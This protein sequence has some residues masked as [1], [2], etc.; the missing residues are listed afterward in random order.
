MSG[1]QRAKGGEDGEGSLGPSPPAL[2]VLTAALCAMLPALAWGLVACNRLH[3]QTA[4]GLP[5]VEVVDI[6][7]S[8]TTGLA[9]AIT[10]THIQLIQENGNDLSIPRENVIEL[11]RTRPLPATG[12]PQHTLLLSNGDRLQGTI[13]G[14]TEES[15]QLQWPG[16]ATATPLDVP[17]ELIRAIVFAE[18]SRTEERDRLTRMWGL[19]AAPVDRL[20][21]RTGAVIDGEL[22]ELDLGTF[23]MQT[24][25]GPVETPQAEV[26]AFAGNPELL[27]LPTPPEEY[28]IA[29][30]A[31][32]DWISLQELAFVDQRQVTGQT[33][34]G[35]NMAIP[36]DQIVR[37]RLFG[38]RVTSL[39]ALQP[40][41]FTFR[42]WL[43]ESHSLVANRNVHGGWLRLQ[44]DTYPRGMGLHSHSEVTY[45]L[46]GKY[47]RFQALVGIDDM[48]GPQGSVTFTVE[49]DGQVAFKSDRITG[50]QPPV[51]VGPLPV[52][53]AKQLRLTVD[54][55]DFGNIRDIADVVKPL[56][57]K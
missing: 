9:S 31:G 7:G 48:A 20:I 5:S 8:V 56:L 11:R 40:S 45:D 47:E 13:T 57:T 37:L 50:D 46:G 23:R 25:L 33:L 24:S 32:G 55:A 52:S 26:A 2:R 3:A 16:G 41:D 34:W 10:P 36:L 30:C 49:V 19:H 42:P 18:P 12:S 44:G 15:A 39:T 53:G 6:V 4:A 21:L 17:L 1:A 14:I 22:Q 51:A 28:V 38:S 54:F 27:S 29:E 35:S 43:S